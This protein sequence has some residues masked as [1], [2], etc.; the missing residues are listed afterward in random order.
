M[1]FADL[2]KNRD[3]HR[4]RESPSQLVNLAKKIWPTQIAQSDRLGSLMIRTKTDIETIKAERRRL[5]HAL[6]QQRLHAWQQKMQPEDVKTISTW[7]RSKEHPHVSVNVSRHGEMAQNNVHASEQIY[8]HWQGVWHEPGRPDP[9]DTVATLTATVPAGNNP[10]QWQPP[11]LATFTNA[12]LDARGTSGCDQ[13]SSD[14]TNYMPIPATQHLHLDA[15]MVSSCRCAAGFF[16]WK[17]DQPSQTKKIRQGMID[18]ADMR[19]IQFFDF[20]A[21]LCHNM[22]KNT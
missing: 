15:K 21:C 17:A 18:A 11:D 9:L 16:L 2:P 1:S 12:V 7:L 19:P 6:Q 20:L 5:A 13:W 14:E 3:A 10:P 4:L 22:D 8:Q